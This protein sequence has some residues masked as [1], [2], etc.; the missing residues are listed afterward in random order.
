MSKRVV[1]CVPDAYVDMVERFMAAQAHKGLSFSMLVAMAMSSYGETDIIGPAIMNV[2][3]ASPSSSIL[4]SVSVD[5]ATVPAKRKRGR[6]KK[7]PER[8]IEDVPKRAESVAAEDAAKRI[9]EPVHEPAVREETNKQDKVQKD[10]SSKPVPDISYKEPG[11]SVPP[12]EEKPYQPYKEEPLYAP[13]SDKSSQ[14]ERSGWSDDAF[15]G[16]DPDFNPDGGLDNVFE[17][18]GGN[19]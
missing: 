6:P 2:P 16:I 14:K 4:S 11:V 18:L 13:R 19:D 1:I 3:F 7:S 9:E 17:L 10:V 8:I 12:E 5:P 15:E